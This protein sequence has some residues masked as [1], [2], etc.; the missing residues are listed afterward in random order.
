M[1]SSRVGSEPKKML[2]KKKPIVRQQ[3]M[4]RRTR[5]NPMAAKRQ[6]EA[7]EYA[8]K[9]KTFLDEKRVCEICHK[10]A[11]CDV[12]HVHG[13]LHGN[14]LDE[15]TWKATCRRCHRLIHDDPKLARMMGWLA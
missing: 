8:K 1:G 13:R 11:S 14:Y 12:H 5:L 7:R 3:A 15:K 10:S 9:R 4:L 6:R 2:H